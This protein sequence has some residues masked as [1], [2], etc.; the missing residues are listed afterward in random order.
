M[1]A[2]GDTIVIGN[3]PSDPATYLKVIGDPID[4]VA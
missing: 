2:V 1:P 4:V 3:D